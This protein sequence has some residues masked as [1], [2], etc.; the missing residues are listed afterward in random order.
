MSLCGLVITSVY[1]DNTVYN[2]GKSGQKTEVY[3]QNSTKGLGSDKAK[4]KN[5]SGKMQ[6]NIQIKE[7]SELK[8]SNTKNANPKN[9]GKSTKNSAEKTIYQEEANR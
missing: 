4:M 7:Q 2:Q 8:N 3:E 1:A 5:N 6:K 9:V